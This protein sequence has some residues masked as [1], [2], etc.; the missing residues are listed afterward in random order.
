[1]LRAPDADKDAYSEYLR[2]RRGLPPV[3]RSGRPWKCF[4]LLSPSQRSRVLQ[5]EKFLKARQAC[6]QT[7]RGRDFRSLCNIV[8]SPRFLP[9]TNHSPALL[10]KTA[11]WSMHHQRLAIP[12]EQVEIQCYKMWDCHPATADWAATLASLT[13]AQQKSLAGNGMHA[14]VVGAAIMFVLACTDC[15]DPP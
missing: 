8:Q 4:H 3:R 11:L 15:T 13:F 10:R 2:S 1:M 12:L 5:H 7:T 14:A 6:G 9:A